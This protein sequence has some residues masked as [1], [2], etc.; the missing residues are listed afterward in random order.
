MGKIK[1]VEQGTVNEL[2]NGSFDPSESALGRIK[3][4]A[5]YDTPFFRNIDQIVY[6]KN[7]EIHIEVQSE[8]PGILVVS[9]S[10][11]PGWKVYVDGEEKKCLWLD[12][13]FQGV[14]IGAGRHDIVFKFRPKHSNLFL[15]ISLTSLVLLFSAWVSLWIKGRFKPSSYR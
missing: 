14:E 15:F 11:Y 9:E 1:K 2:T 3:I 8:K 13:L 6:Q 10:S 4:E 5:Q 7:G 12:L